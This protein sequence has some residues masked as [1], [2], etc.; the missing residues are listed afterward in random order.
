LNATARI[1]AALAASMLVLV[2]GCSSSCAC[3]NP[4][5]IVTESV[6]PNATTSESPTPSVTAQASASPLPTLMASTEPTGSA[7]AGATRVEMYALAFHPTDL[8]IPAGD[9]QFFLVNP[10]DKSLGTH[11][12]A[13]GPKLYQTLAANAAVPLGESAVFSVQGLAPGTY[14]VWCTI[15]GHASEGMVGTLTVH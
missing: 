10:A 8:S 13:I 3:A 12:M 6:A 5:P 14:V 4:S 7:P 15:D 2:T 1:G 11:S 9:G